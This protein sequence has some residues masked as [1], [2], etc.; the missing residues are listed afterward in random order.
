MSQ[1]AGMCLTATQGPGSRMRYS[2]S[3][4][5][6]QMSCCCGQPEAR[7]CFAPPSRRRGGRWSNRVGVR[8]SRRGGTSPRHPQTRRTPTDGCPHSASSSPARAAGKAHHITTLL[9]LGD[10][11]CRQPAAQ[12]TTHLTRHPRTGIGQ[13]L[14]SRTKATGFND[15]VA[16]SLCTVHDHLDITG[17]SLMALLRCS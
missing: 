12:L 6:P 5:A 13:N 7:R 1:Q 2:I 17:W 8:T 9:R 15:N 10:E 16:R 4:P 11:Q 14:T 3:K